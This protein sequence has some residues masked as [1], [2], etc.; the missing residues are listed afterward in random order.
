MAVQILVLYPV[1]AIKVRCQRD[2]IGASEVVSQLAKQAAQPGGRAGVLRLLYSG[3]GSSALFSIAVGSVHCKVHLGLH[4]PCVQLPARRSFML[5]VAIPP[6]AGLSFCTAKRAALDLLPGAPLASNGAGGRGRSTNEAIPCDGTGER[7][8][9]IIRNDQARK[10]SSSASSS[11]AQAP[12]QNPVDSTDAAV[13]QDNDH[14][15]SK[16]MLANV[17]A[18]A[19]GALATAVIESPVELFR[20]QAQVSRPSSSS[21][22]RPRSV[23]P[24]FPSR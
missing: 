1:E 22:I 17:I 13:R 14:D 24:S 5:V 7:Q 15:L 11:S 20:H 18:A 6:L 12:V 3:I 8:Q 19:F 16:R 21:A 9:D 23:N 2:S 10:L 4:L